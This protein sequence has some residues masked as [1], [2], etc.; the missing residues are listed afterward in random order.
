PWG[1]VAAEQGVERGPLLATVDGAISRASGVGQL[2]APAA[3][4]VSASGAPARPL[5][6]PV[7]SEVGSSVG[8]PSVAPPGPG[9]PP[10]ASGEPAPAGGWPGGVPPVQPQDDPGTGLGIP[11][12]DETVDILSGLLRA[13]G[14]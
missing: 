4:P 9:S 12:L 1:L 14:G 2:A 13:I 10:P 7:P 5:P 6:V 3:P 11:L 8:S